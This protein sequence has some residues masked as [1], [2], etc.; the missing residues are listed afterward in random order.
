MTAA[1]VPPPPSPNGNL[2]RV[3]RVA[4]AVT[5]ASFALLLIYGAWSARTHPVAAALGAGLLAVGALAVGALVGFLFG[6]PVSAVAVAQ[7]Q[8]DPATAGVPSATSTTAQAT[9]GANQLVQVAEWLTRI[10]IGATLTQ[11][12]ALRDQIQ[13][14]GEQSSAQILGSGRGEVVFTAAVVYGAVFGF[15][16]GHL[17][18]RLILNLLFDQVDA[19]PP[20]PAAAAREVLDAPGK[21]LSSLSPTVLNAVAEVDEARLTRPEDLRAWGLARVVADRD[22]PVASARGIAA[23]TRAVV[24]SPGDRAA[25]ESLVLGALYAPAPDGFRRALQEIEAYLARHPTPGPDAANLFAYLA[26][27]HGQAY[28]WAKQHAD[29]PGQ[30]THRVEALAAVEQTLRLDATWGAFLRRLTRPDSVDDDLAVL[31]QDAPELLA[32]LPPS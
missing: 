20:L 5:G 28:A 11:L 32:R 27:A 1:V 22:D 4:L 19:R 14:L 24:A 25:L 17:S 31:A 12:A 29:L 30:A 13:T 10:L 6:V 18:T 16:V 2:T 7:A 9:R 23:L 15:F 26:C 3:T 8:A 21:K